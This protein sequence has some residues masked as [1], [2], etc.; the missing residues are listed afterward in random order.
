MKKIIFT[1]MGIFALTLGACAH[2]PATAP[3]DGSQAEAESASLRV[4]AANSFLADIAQNVAGDRAEVESLIPIGLDPHAFEP[5]PLDVAKIADS[6]VLIVNGAGFEEWLEKTIENAGGSAK[7]IEASAGLEMREG[8]E[9]E[10][11]HDHDD[12]SVESHSAMVCEQLEGKTAEDE[13]VAGA[14]AE[15]AAELHHHEEGTAEHEHGREIINIKLTAQADGTYAGFLLFDVETEEGYAFTSQAGSISVSDKQGN[16]LEPAQELALECGGMVQGVIYKLA[17]GEYLISL[18]G[19]SAGNT[20]FSAAPVHAHEHEG[21]ETDEH[22]AED[23]A[24]HQHEGDPHFWLDPNQVVAYA[25][26]IRNG[27]SEIDPAGKDTYAKNAADYIEQLRELDTWIR[28]Q[29]EQIPAER[30]VLVTDHDTLGYFAD[31]YGFSV[32]G[33]IIPSFSTGASPSAQ[34]L[35]GLI[36]QINDTGAPAI[37]LDVAANPKLADQ[38]AAETGVTVVADLHTH[39]VTAANGPAAT[40]I[41]MMRHN[42]LR[43]VEALE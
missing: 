20:P 17:P 23:H 35:A 31:Q 37:F 40:Y 38:I 32:T 34:E 41:E 7:I 21:E 4:L 30:R 42:T 43:I 15:N 3:E 16:A 9:G 14:D 6:Q 27:L 39:S 11:S 33:A 26:N 24:E 13:A 22:A 36:D 19:F 1:I 8:G 28:A 10:P 18:T 12:H 25:E 29:V 2:Q 5:T